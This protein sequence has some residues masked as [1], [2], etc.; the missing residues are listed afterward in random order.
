MIT[1]A[2]SI[3]TPTVTICTVKVMCHA[4]ISFHL[5][6][7]KTYFNCISGSPFEY[8]VPIQTEQQDLCFHRRTTIKDPPKFENPQRNSAGT[9]L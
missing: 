6:K 5:Q 4:N 1:H 9:Y 8:V 7:I 2:Y 3:H